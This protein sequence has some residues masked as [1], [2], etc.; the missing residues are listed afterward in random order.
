MTHALRAAGA[1]VPL[2]LL[3]AC[4]PPQED[5][6]DPTFGD[7]CRAFPTGTTP[8]DVAISTCDG[9][10]VAL[11]PA[12]GDARLDVFDLA[13]GDLVAS[14]FFP[15]LDGEGGARFASPWSVAVTPDGARAAVTL[16][17]Q[18]LVAWVDPCRGEVLST[19]GVDGAITPQP[20]VLLEGRVIVAFTNIRAF[21]IDG[22][23][24]VLDDGVV[25]A[26]HVGDDALVLDTAVTTTGLK[27]PQG[28]AAGAGD[29]VVSLSG[30]LARGPDGGQAAVT[31]GALLHLDGGTLATKSVI[32]AGT[33]APGTPALL[34]TQIVVGSLVDPE[35]FAAPLADGDLDDVPPSA[36]LALDG[37]DVEA[38]FEVIRWSADTA[39]VTQF[40]ADALRAVRVDAQGLTLV[41]TIRVGPGGDAFRG[42]LAVDARPELDGDLQAAGLLGLSAELVPLDLRAALPEVTP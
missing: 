14:T 28:L 33:H 31:P 12:S 29:V 4:P 21:S 19:A 9:R 5:T 39:L 30:A 38:L 41:D 8:N 34:G 10:R 1:L 18:D 20:V 6:C 42:L 13:H 24:P 7:A 3:A 22:E 37:P 25:A 15:P 16:F 11:V 23:P 40:S 26:F 35:V 36:H 27:N 2:A 32:R 17:G